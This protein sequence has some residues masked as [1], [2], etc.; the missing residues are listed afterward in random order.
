MPHTIM[1]LIVDSCERAE[2]YARNLLKTLDELVKKEDLWSHNSSLRN[3]LDASMRYARDALYFVEKGDCDTALVASSY[4]EGL[5]DA[6]KYMGVLGFEWKLVAEEELERRVFVAGTFDLIHPGHIELLRFAS[7]F[8]KVYVV[9]ARDENVVKNKG[10]RP[11]LPE[12]IRLKIV[13]SIKYVYK[14]L[15][16]DKDNIYSPLLRIQPDIVVLGPDQ[17]FEEKQLEQ[18]I[19]QLLGKNIK[20]IRF[21]NKIEFNN[22]MRGSRDIIRKI[23]CESYCSDIQCSQS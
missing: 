15:L 5:L 2:K 22:N 7:E 19:T 10:R 3:L 20:V 13:S 12:Y 6:L 17:P 21:K 9:V 23:C 11:I 14:A 4:A 1:V 8:G 16:G 18:K